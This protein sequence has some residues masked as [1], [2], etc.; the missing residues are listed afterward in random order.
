MGIKITQ[1][2]ND[3]LI[4]MKV[5]GTTFTFGLMDYDYDIFFKEVVKHPPE[6]EGI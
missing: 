6:R 3:W 1:R 2:E 4:E 5:N